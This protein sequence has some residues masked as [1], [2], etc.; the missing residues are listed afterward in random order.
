MKYI[1]LL[2]LLAILVAGCGT[3]RGEGSAVVYDRMD[4]ETCAELQ[5][6]F[7]QAMANWDRMRRQVSLDYATYANKVMRDRC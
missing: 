4:T 2:T 5:A 1:L 3:G 7:D 6:D